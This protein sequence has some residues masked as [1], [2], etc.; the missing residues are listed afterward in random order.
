MLKLLIIGVVV[1]L[2]LRGLRGVFGGE[3]RAPKPAAPEH[4]EPMARCAR[5]GVYLPASALSK[6][7]LCG[8]CAGA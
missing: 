8:N 6:S 2:L 7:G 5:C 3:A 4:Y 1:W